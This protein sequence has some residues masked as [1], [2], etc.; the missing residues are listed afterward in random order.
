[1]DNPRDEHVMTS[2]ALDLLELTPEQ[3]AWRE[4]A[5]TML[6][7]TRPIDTGSTSGSTEGGCRVDPLGLLETRDNRL[8]SAHREH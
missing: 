2:H 3:L 7:T 1:M 4:R 8:W 6:F 5:V